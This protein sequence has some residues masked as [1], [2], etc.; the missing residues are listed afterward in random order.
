VRRIFRV[1]RWF[2]TSDAERSMK[3]QARAKA[4]WTKRTGRSGPL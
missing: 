3:Q 4:V 1:L 2:R